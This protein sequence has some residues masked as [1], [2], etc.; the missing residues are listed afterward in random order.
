MAMDREKLIRF[1]ET[2]YL[3]RQEVLF[4][5]PLNLSIDAFWPELLGRRKAKATVLP[6]SNPDGMPYWYTL[7]D[8]MIAA[9]ERLCEEAL[10]QTESID[11]YRASMTSAMTE[12]MFFTSFVEGAQI[13]FADAMDFLQ[14]GTDPE[15]IQEQMIW[16]NRHAWEMLMATLYRPIDESFIKTLSQT[17]TEGMDG[18]TEEYRQGDEHPIAAMSGEGY[19]LPS[20]FIL[21]ERMNEL[22]AFLRAPD[23]HPLIKA[24]AAQAFI[25]VTRPFDEGNERLARMLSAAILLRC[26]YD[27][28]R[29]ISLSAVLAGENYLYY[30][31]MREI[32]RRENGDD[33]TYF[34]EYY[35]DL[36]ARAVDA[37]KERLRRREQEALIAEIEMAKQPLGGRVK[38]A[39]S[40]VRQEPTQ[41]IQ[42]RTGNTAIDE[43]GDGGSADGG[44]NDGKCEAATQDLSPEEFDALLN[45][46]E[47]DRY[48]GLKKW[49]EKVRKMISK[50]FYTFTVDQWAEQTGMDRKT[51]DA[52]CRGIFN[53]GLL[54]K[55]RSGDVMR[56]SFRIV[57]LSAQKSEKESA[58]PAQD[59]EAEAEKQPAPIPMT[60]ELERKLEQL[61]NSKIGAY[62]RSAD[63][64]RRLLSEGR[65]TF[66]RRLWPN[67]IKSMKAHSDNACDRMRALGIIR[68]VSKEV[69][70]AVYT[71]I[72]GNA[73]E[74]SESF[75]EIMEKLID[76]KENGPNDR[77]R[78][79][80]S[81]LL[82]LAER[83]KKHFTTTD[84]NREFHVSK[85]V[86]GNDLRRALNLGLVQKIAI[87]NGGNPCI[88]ELCK[89]IATDLRA[90]S[91]T[92]V[93]RQ[94]LSE[95]YDAFRDRLFTVIDG[96]GVLKVSAPTS[97]FHLKNFADRGLLEEHRCPGRAFKYSFRVNPKNNPKCF[98][99]AERSGRVMRGTMPRAIPGGLAA[100][101]G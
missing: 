6:L 96:A 35:I 81:F 67:E 15:N 23:I 59:E 31:H 92:L 49:P 89:Q 25:L 84:W 9:S 19:R 39:D 5:L 29:D 86:Y 43:A 61:A 34:M 68:N 4:K 80:G 16:N 18:G 65:T 82:G 50:G 72:V 37:R 14:R 87:G 45:K 53:K 8:K 85:T 38:I 97:S 75:P 48:G 71:I 95:L 27:F 1:L 32:L 3:S 24:S 76:L 51:A 17:L 47:N 41:A 73:D 58:T 21:G 44:L 94:N 64:I 30:K 36:L 33:L 88:Y 20:A 46:Y 99:R 13:S 83:G 54:H 79:I 62:R 70:P 77:D 57:R 100:A 22:C 90:E 69:H 7:T 74:E 52:E 101:A 40:P 12:E 10:S 42:P 98:A 66:E 28:F 60:E 11:P 91:L 63:A 55:D 2:N 26:G 93:Q 78:R 56:Y